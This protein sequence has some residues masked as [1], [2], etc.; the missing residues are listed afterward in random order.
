MSKSIT[1]TLIDDLNT[2]VS[3]AEALLAATA[4]ETNDATKKVRHKAAASL[5]RAKASLEQIQEDLGE[6]AKAVADDV[7]DYVRENPWQS[8]GIAAAAGV[9][10]GVLLGRR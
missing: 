8:I 7:T 10:I 6:R 4:G 1:H 5:D 3:D 2:V 9:V